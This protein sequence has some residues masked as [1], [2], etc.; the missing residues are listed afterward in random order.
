MKRFFSAA[1]M[2]AFAILIV[3]GCGK[4]PDERMFEKG[5]KL[6]ARQKFTQAISQ[7][8]QLIKKF[9]KSPQVPGALYN[10][11]NVYMY[12]LQDYPKAVETFS[13]IVAEFPDSL[14]V[15]AQSQFLIGF[16]YNNYA[17]DT[18]KARAAYKTFLEKYP[19]N[20]LASSVKWEMENLGKDI[21]SNP[22]FKK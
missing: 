6:E 12:G 11:G 20:E 3:A 4:M 8:E 7:Y 13:K 1:V 5:R 21:N 15:T 22:M 14:K 9:P 17:P 10:I 18:S 16:V 19:D 2:T